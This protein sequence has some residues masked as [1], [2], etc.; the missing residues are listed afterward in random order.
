MRYLRRK[1]AASEMDIT[2]LIDCVFILLIFFMIS[3]TFVKDMKIDL[4]RPSAASAQ[5]A[6]TKAIRVYVEKNG[7]VTIDGQPVKPW[8]VQS[9]V[10]DF[11]KSGR[12]GAVLVVADRLAVAEKL[13][14]I[15]DQC[16]LGG[17][18][19]VAVAT[20]KEIPQ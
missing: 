13:I 12:S 6:S 5:K 7:A 2:P 9:R 11:V 18:T 3:T 8:M 19:D 14:E 20:E 15:V 16:R 1:A 10:R 4:Q 17:A